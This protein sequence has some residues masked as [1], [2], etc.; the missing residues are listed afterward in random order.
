MANE[1]SIVLKER[2][3]SVKSGLPADLNIQRYVNNAVALMNSNDQLQDF[4][5][6]YGVGQI[7]SGLMRGAYLGLDAMLKEYYLIPYEAKLDFRIDYRGEQ[8]LVKKYSIRPVKEIYAKVVRKGDEFIEKIVNGVPTIDFYPLPFNE[9]PVI[10]AF[11]VCLF[12]DGGIAYEVMTLDELNACEAKS[13][14]SGAWRDFP[15]EMRK[16]SV[17]RRLCKQMEIDFETP[18]QLEIFN[19]D[20]GMDF[21]KKDIKEEVAENANSEEFVIEGEWVEEDE[22]SDEDNA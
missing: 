19:E 1:L 13:K 8:K 11:A 18:E 22:V 10:G 2:L 5:R 16:K 14:K 3:E 21:S 20:M 4:A 9:S 15:N 6:M 12:E 17:I 7:V